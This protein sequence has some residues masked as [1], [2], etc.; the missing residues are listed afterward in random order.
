MISKKFLDGE[1]NMTLRIVQKLTTMKTH[2]KETGGEVNPWI[3]ASCRDKEKEHLQHKLSIVASR[4]NK[5]EK[6]VC[7]Y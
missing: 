5:G 4:R 3:V 2:A 6:N 1:L 7:T